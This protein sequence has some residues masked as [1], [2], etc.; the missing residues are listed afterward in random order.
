MTV[1]TVYI[2]DLDDTTFHWDGGDWS[3]NIPRPLAPDFPPASGHYNDC[4]HKWVKRMG[5]DCKQTDFGGW[6][7]K[8]TQSQLFNYIDYCY[9]TDPG[10]N[11]PDKMLMWEGRPYLVDRLD[12]LREFV[13]DINGSKQYA[14]VATEF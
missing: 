8:V 4:Y 11:D 2:G 5:I 14:L 6:V 1:C 13:S 9:G 12:A 10:Y 7:T 3:G